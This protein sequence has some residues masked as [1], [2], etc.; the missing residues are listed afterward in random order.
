V[1]IRIVSTLYP[2]SRCVKSLVE[3]KESKMSQVTQIMGLSRLNSNLG[4][5]VTY[6]IV[7]TFVS[8][9]STML[10]SL[11]FLPS[12]DPT[13]VFA[14][15]FLFHMSLIPF[16]F[17]MSTLFDRAKIASIVAPVALFAFMLPRY[18]N[19]TYHEHH[20]IRSCFDE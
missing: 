7:F 6:G 9:T 4:H 13:L 3:E 14:F 17:M 10:S 15:Y 20:I 18:G 8:V 19:L 5:I 1:Y 16:C 12:S 11:T 2:V